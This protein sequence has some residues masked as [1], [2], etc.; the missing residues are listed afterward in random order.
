MELLKDYDI[1]ILYHLGK[2][3]VVEDALSRKAESMGSL[4]F[5]PAVGR[6]LAMD[7]QAFTKRFI[8]FDIPHPSRVLVCVVSQT[9]LFEHI[10]ARQYDDPHFLILKDMV[11]RG[12]AKE[13]TISDDG[14]L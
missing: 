4:N 1:T 11:L 9:F 7:V 5:I 10:K 13:V 14:V 3:N 8:I 12:V 6:P 2:A